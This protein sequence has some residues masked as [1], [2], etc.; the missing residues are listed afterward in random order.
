[1][2]LQIIKNNSFWNAI[3]KLTLRFWPVEINMKNPFSHIASKY[4][5]FENLKR[6]IVKVIS[7][8]PVFNNAVI[9]H[10]SIAQVILPSF[11][12]AAKMVS[13]H[14]AY[15]CIHREETGSHM[16]S[17]TTW[18]CPEEMAARGRGA[19]GLRGSHSQSTAKGRVWPWP[20]GIAP[21]LFWTPHTSSGSNPG[22]TSQIAPGRDGH[23]TAWAPLGVGT[24]P[25]SWPPG[26]W[27][28][29]AG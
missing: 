10:C 17:P 29:A 8:H 4:K 25:G 19:Q 11:S 26:P 24:G 22:L 13:A 20:Q 21:Y 14:H 2:H 9:S 16:H 15:R 12:H 27:V 3:K 5:L 28:D 7:Q 23:S 18:G 6:A 1:M